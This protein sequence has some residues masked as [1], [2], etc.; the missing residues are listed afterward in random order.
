MIKQKPISRNTFL[1]LSVGLLLCFFVWI[2]SRLSGFQTERQNNQEF[3]H[4]M[5]LPMGVSYYDTYYIFRNDQTVRAFR[6][7]CTHA[8][9]RISRGA[10]TRMQCNCHGSQFEAETGKP[11]RGPAMKPLAE[12]DCRFDEKKEQWVVRMKPIK[13]NEG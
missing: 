5:D 7:T 4:G 13:E 6:T 8:G 9:C 1:R 2:W 10:G 11:L 3:R 12:L